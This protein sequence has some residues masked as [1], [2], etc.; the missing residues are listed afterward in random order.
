MDP[1]T[2][3]SRLCA[4]R[5]SAFPET[6]GP[7]P[8]AHRC[9]AAVPSARALAST[10]RNRGL[11]LRTK[12]DFR[13]AIH[14]FTR[15]VA[16]SPNDVTALSNRGYAYRKLGDFD[17]AAK[18]YTSALRLQP[19][20]VRLHNNRGYCLA[21]LAKYKDAISDY[22]IVIEASLGDRLPALL[23]L[24]V[25]PGWAPCS[26]L[27][28][29]FFEISSPSSTLSPSFYPTPTPSPSFSPTLTPTPSPSPS[30]SFSP[31]FSPT[32]TPAPSALDLQLD[33]RNTHAYHNRGISYDKLG[34]YDEAIKD[35]TRVLQ[36][37]PNNVNAY[38]NRG[39]A[40]DSI[41][42]Y[43]AAVQDYRWVVGVGMH[44]GTATVDSDIKSVDL[45]LCMYV[46]AICACGSAVCLCVFVGNRYLSQ[47]GFQAF[48]AMRHSC[49]VPCRHHSQSCTRFGRNQH[50]HA[51]DDT[52]LWHAHWHNTI[53]DASRDA[54]GQHC[55]RPVRAGVEARL[56]A[57][58]TGEGRGKD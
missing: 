1:L 17:A 41:G 19:R 9:T 42:N 31:S 8:V 39:S 28:A 57:L 11:C 56:A 23:S 26:P 5:T 12:N 38:F 16:L 50:K 48:G 15:V 49:R 3:S 45:Y 51:Q 43:E 37:E 13:A 55:A 36:L 2:F 25:P 34:M 29:S 53:P 47:A 18:D 44:F 24:R 10:R 46:Y 7:A 40:Y 52:A 20:T 21:K 27:C 32:P 58:C 22:D 33:P 30:P 6:A 14:D 35:F 54:P 4:A